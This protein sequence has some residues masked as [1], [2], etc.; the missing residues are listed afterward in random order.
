VPVSAQAT[1]FIPALVCDILVS[2]GKDEERH[3]Q[4]DIHAPLLVITG[5]CLACRNVT[6]AVAVTMTLRE[7]RDLDLALKRVAQLEDQVRSVNNSANIYL[8]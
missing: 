7:H 1:A 5:R 4:V 8:S 3:Q 2:R 6:E